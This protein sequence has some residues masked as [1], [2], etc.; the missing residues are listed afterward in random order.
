MKELLDI[1]KEIDDTALKNKIA[2]NIA[3]ALCG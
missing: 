2:Y 3:M 1:L